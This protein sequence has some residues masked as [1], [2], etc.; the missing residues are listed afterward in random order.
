MV[1]RSQFPHQ[2]SLR[3]DLEPLFRDLVLFLTFFENYFDV[4]IANARVNDLQFFSPRM[5]R[6]RLITLL[7]GCSWHV[8]KPTFMVLIEILSTFMASLRRAVSAH[9]VWPAAR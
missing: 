1:Y 7:W 6:E 8:R 2:S 3:C 4:S 9:M 5:F